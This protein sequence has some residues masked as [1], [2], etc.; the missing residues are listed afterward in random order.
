MIIIKNSTFKLILIIVIIAFIA[1]YYIAN[2]GYY[3]YDLQKRTVL[4]REKIKEFENDVQNNKD[5]DIK[6]YLA[7]EEVSYTNK[8]TNLVYNTSDKGT[9][10]MRSFLKA[11]FKKISY[12]VED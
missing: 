12:L 11:V 6:D 2:S 9:S 5:I 10:L 1:S 8:I 7:E 3:E 4:T